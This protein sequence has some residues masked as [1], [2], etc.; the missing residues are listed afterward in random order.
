MTFAGPVRAAISKASDPLPTMP[1]RVHK[2]FLLRHLAAKDLTVVLICG[3]LIGS[4][5]ASCSLHFLEGG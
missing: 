4:G 5:R 2:S 3:M 1:E